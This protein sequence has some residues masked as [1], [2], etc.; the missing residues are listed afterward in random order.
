M[1]ERFRNLLIFGRFVFS[2]KK[3]NTFALFWLNLV[4][5]KV[6]KGWL[7]AQACKQENYFRRLLRGE[8]AKIR[9]FTINEFYHF[10]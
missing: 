8:V 1:D 4:M 6:V 2:S 10:T 3:I 9:N 5:S 7:K